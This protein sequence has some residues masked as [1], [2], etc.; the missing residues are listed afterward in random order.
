MCSLMPIFLPKGCR[1]LIVTG[2]YGSGKTEFAVSLAMALAADNTSGYPRIAVCDLDVVNPYF[3]S[4]ERSDMLE[5]VGVRVYGGIYGKGTTAEIPELSAAVRAPMEDAG[6]FTIIDAGGNDSGARILKQFEKYFSHNDTYIAAVV[7]ASRPETSTTEGAIEQL[8]AIEAEL[9]MD[10][11]GLVSNTHMLTET[12]ASD[13]RR[14]YK[15]CQQ[16]AENMSKEF[17]C[18]CYPEKLIDL[19]EISDIRVQKMPLGMY[20]RQSWLDK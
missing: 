15:F 12:K 4:R 6:C 17:L 7:N 20:M 14:G 13:I 19:S 3:R 5:S 9:G 11:N 1:I 8:M 2:H 18:V 16:L 10:I